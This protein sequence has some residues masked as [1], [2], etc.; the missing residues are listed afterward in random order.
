[1]QVEQ[2]NI[3]E[4]VTRNAK[5]DNSNRAIA[6][7]QANMPDAG[8]VAAFGGQEAY[9]QQKTAVSEAGNIDMATYSNP[10]KQ[11]QEEKTV[12]EKIAGQ[13][14]S[15]G[16]AR[17]NE[18][19][20]V[21]NTTSTEDL[22]KME[23]DGF[24]ISDADSH[25]IITVTDKIKA[26]LAKAGVD[27]SSMGGTL[28][29]EQLEEI[30]GS[31]VVTQQIMDSLAANDLPATEENVQ[32]SAE[33]LAQAASIPEITKQAMSYL[34]KNDME[35]T[36]RNLYLSNYS[37]SAENIVEP[38]QSGIDFESLMPQIREIIAEAGLSDDE[39]AVDNSKWLV[40]NQIPLTPENLQYLTDLQGL[41]DDLQ[42]DHIDW[43]QIVDSMAKAIAAGKRPSDASMITARRQMEEARLVMTSEASVAMEKA[44]VEMDLTPL[45]DLVED[46]K[47]QEREYYKDLLA[48]AGV[49]PSEKNVDL[50]AETMD[51]F[52]ELKQQ[53]A[54][55][56][57]QIDADDSVQEI[58]DAGA[59]MQ[60]AFAQANE[61]YETL[62]TAP[63][64][65]MGDSIT[66]AFS[67]VDDILQDLQLD[68]S[69]TNRRAVRILAYNNTEITPENI[70]E[71]KALDEQMQRAFSNMKPAVTLEMIRRGEN[72]LDMTM[73]Q[74]NQAAQEIQQENGTQEQER[75]SKYLWKLE[76]NHEISEEER[77]SYI[78]IY[79]LIAQVEKGDGAALGFLMNQGSDVTMR[80]LLHAVRSE[81]KSGLDYQVDDDFDGVDSTAEGPK[82]DEQISAAFQQNCLRDVMEH[83]S[84]EKLSRLGE[85]KWQNMSPEQ[86]AEAL[87]QMD[88]SVGEQEAEK[89]YRQEQL[90]QYQQLAETPEDVYTYLERYDIPNSMVNVMAASEMLRKPN[91]MM[92]RLFQQDHVSK[93]SMTEIAEMKEQVLEQF[94]KALENPSDLADAMETLADVAEHVMDTMIVEDPDVRTIDIREMRQMTAQFQI[95]A[96]QSQEECYVIPMQTGDS[97]TGVSLKIVRGKK[98]KGL[99]DIFLDGEKAGKITASFQVKSDRISGTIVTGSEETAKQI[100]EHLQE[101]QDAMQEPADIH[102]AYTP[103]LSL[104]QFEMSGIRRE[105][106]MKE[107]G[108][109]EK[110]RSNQVQTTRLYHTAEVFI[111]SIKSLLTKTKDL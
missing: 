79:R 68:T 90:A 97:V 17:S 46:L 23:E 4:D 106:E 52:A 14:I 105:S 96:K 1:M 87:R 56:I 109:L 43:N 57:G 67:N 7:Y 11:G 62:M 92:E 95:G 64:S 72:P 27:V 19:A 49:E 12:A 50:M 91:R 82:I 86:L 45:A 35:P 13:E 21:A 111:N 18:I 61:S 98:K 89:S 85:E 70:M 69:E 8:A 99:V 31:P 37:S 20:V 42:T 26:A 78:G 6:A 107:Q 104:S 80:N 3:W 2:K 73:E 25:T 16:Q 34:L 58:H 5:R 24:S 28:T 94:S 59:Q 100:E 110:D 71:V 51:V 108:E 10:A 36:I 53:P 63:R 41:S 38:E 9:V 74:L 22:K 66:K 84:P 44:G 33:A 83:I 29:K 75:F 40:A 39:H 76:Q 77:S 47:S 88:E 81:K 60:R 55:V 103:D 93:D 15:S 54:Y 30:T 65:D 101:M 102:V 32:D 48:G